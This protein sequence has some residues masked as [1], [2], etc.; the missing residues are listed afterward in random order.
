MEIYVLLI[1][2]A[3]GLPAKDRKN[4]YSLINEIKMQ[5]KAIILYTSSIEE[6]K[7]S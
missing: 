6:L 3:Y 4:F 5:N 1:D 2:P 7:R